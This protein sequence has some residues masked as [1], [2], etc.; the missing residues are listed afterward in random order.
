LRSK[1]ILH[2]L[3]EKNSIAAT[4][5]NFIKS[6][7]AKVIEIPEL[8]YEVKKLL[9]GGSESGQGI[10]D[11][12]HADYRAQDTGERIRGQVST[13]TTIVRRSKVGGDSGKPSTNGIDA[14][15]KLRYAFP[16]N[17]GNILSSTYYSQFRDGFFR[18]MNPE[19]DRIESGIE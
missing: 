14:H 5:D 8:Q 15:K 9:R 17:T 11:L 2:K 10:L 19:S 18:M 1:R 6:Y 3:K 4:D 12:I 13:T 7:F 16:N